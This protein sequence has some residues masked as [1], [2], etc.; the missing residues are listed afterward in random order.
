MDSASE[1]GIFLLGPTSEGLALSAYRNTT[2]PNLVVRA[3][4]GNS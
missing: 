3:T 2:E 4:L 1:A